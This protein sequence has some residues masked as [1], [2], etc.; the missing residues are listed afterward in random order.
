M[1]QSDIESFFLGA[2]PPWHTAPK[3]WLDD[4][5][6]RSTT[7]A[8]AAGLSGEP[9]IHIC[10]KR[11]LGV[12]KPGYLQFLHGCAFFCAHLRPFALF[13]ILA[14]ALF[15]AHLSSFPRVW[16]SLRPTPFRTTAFG[17]FR[18]NLF[19]TCSS[20]A[21]CISLEVHALLLP[22]TMQQEERARC[23]MELL[24]FISRTSGLNGPFLDGLFAKRY[25]GGK[26][27]HLRHSGKRPT[28]VRKRPL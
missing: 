12:P 14:F 10:K 22:K 4:E 23:D 8:Q 7:L 3:S 11:E 6:E 26:A 17:N 21:R 2:R 16:L 13:C 24:P 1:T 9:H 15:C 19:S 20:F 5:E 18:E 27:A 25:S 28:E